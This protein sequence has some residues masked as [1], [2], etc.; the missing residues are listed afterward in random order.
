M[1]GQVIQGTKRL[2]DIAQNPKSTEDQ[3]SLRIASESPR[4]LAAWGGLPECRR[5]IVLVPNGDMDQAAH[6]PQR[7]W[8]L[9]VQAKS[10][11]L[12]LALA[13]DYESEMNARRQLAL[14]AAITRDKRV[15]VE[16]Q[17]AHT[18]N[19]VQALKSVLQPGDL[20]LS[21]AEL[22]TRKGLF[23]SEPLSE[24]LYNSFSI[25]VYLISGYAHIEPEKTPQLL[26]LFLTGV[27]LVLI[28]VGFFTLDEQ[29]IRQLAGVAQ[30]ATL[31]LMVLLEIGAIWL[32]NYIA[33]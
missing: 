7:I 30:Q 26:R 5:I 33:G 19:W 31:L 1:T 15:P 10:C 9:A 18:S 29:I 13:G 20:I 25:P 16:T 24:Q 23:G 6:L 28:L 14:L 2:E 27:L 17:V 22:I 4:I 12:Y 21:H 8:Q 32:W 3:Q 11:V